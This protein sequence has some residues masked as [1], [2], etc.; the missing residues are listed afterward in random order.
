[1]TE[2]SKLNSTKSRIRTLLNSR[3]IIINERTDTRYLCDMI[4]L[5]ANIEGETKVPISTVP[6]TEK[7]RRKKRVYIL[8]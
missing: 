8:R 4:K 2:S 3:K 6:R 1:M 5:T 7:P